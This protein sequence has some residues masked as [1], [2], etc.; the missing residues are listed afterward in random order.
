MICVT[1]AEEET[2]EGQGNV[3]GLSSMLGGIPDDVPNPP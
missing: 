1:E 2:H 3:E